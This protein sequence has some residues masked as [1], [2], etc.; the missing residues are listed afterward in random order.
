MN[1]FI[2]IEEWTKLKCDEILFDS[3]VD[4]WSIDTSTFNSKILNKDKLLFIIEDREDNKFGGYIDSIIDKT[5]SYITDPKSFIFSIESKGRL[6]S[7][8]KFDID[9]LQYAF[10]LY[11]KSSVDLFSIGNC[12]IYI[13]KKGCKYKPYCRQSVFNYEGIQIHYVEKKVL[14]IHLNYN[15]L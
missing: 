9:K 4:N 11:N 6:N 13:Y 12:D 14:I 7:M 1:Q 10:R 8:K 15:D 2:Q 3:D 5:S